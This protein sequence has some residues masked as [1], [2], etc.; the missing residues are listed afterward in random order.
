VTFGLRSYDYAEKLRKLKRQWGGKCV[1]CGV[2]RSKKKL[3]GK[4]GPLEFAHLPG[5]PTG[6]CGRNRGSRAVYLDVIRHP[7]CY[8]LLC[9]E[10]H[11]LLDL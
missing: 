7:Q 8:V 1:K 9:H 2:T 3:R 6:L 10:C 5:K 4:V 11:A